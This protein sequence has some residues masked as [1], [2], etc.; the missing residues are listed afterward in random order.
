MTTIKV[1]LLEY[2]TKQNGEAPLMLR[3]TKD[4]KAKFINLGFSIKPENWDNKKSCVKKLHPNSVR[5][6][7]LIADK[8]AEAQQKILDLE[9]N[10]TDV[11]SDEIR[12]LIKGKKSNN[13][14]DFAES[15]MSKLKAEGKIG[16]Y[17]KYQAVISK[18]KLYLNNKPLC[19]EE[20]NFNFL[21]EYEAYLRE[22]LNNQQNTIHANLKVVRK[23]VYDAVDESILPYDKNPFL[24]YKMRIEKVEKIYLTEHEIQLLEDCILTEGS[25]K[26]IH[27]NLFIFS[28]Y[29]GGLRISD[30]LQLKW[31]DY[32]GERISK[33]TQKTKEN[34][35]ILL[36]SKAKQILDK[37]RLPDSKPGDFIFPILK[38]NKDYANPEVIFTAISSATAYTNS[39]LKEIGRQAG[40]E[41]SFGFHTSRHTFATRA[42]RKGMRIEHVSKLLGHNSIKTT[43]I[44]TK[45][46]NEE[47]DK[48][49][50]VFD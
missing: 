10:S 26:D 5:F 2:K 8:I 47:L 31:S 43:E 12:N 27:R 4:R 41:K 33:V 14:F 13:F 37:Y 45:I 16:S 25:M 29:S 19:F 22:K 42:L 7:A 34:I 18:L 46:V 30:V 49:M 23:L 11:S 32:D 36:P 24:R 40:I 3:I 20:I 38:S 28:C 15:H 50:A 1:V 39:N 21:K 44:Y 35:S 9:L 6:N 17:R 48:A